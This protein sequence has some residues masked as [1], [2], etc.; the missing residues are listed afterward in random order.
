MVFV[1]LDLSLASHGEVYGNGAFVHLIKY[2][3][4]TWSPVLWS[5]SVITLPRWLVISLCLSE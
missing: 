4:N 1:R 2:P 3:L 5:F